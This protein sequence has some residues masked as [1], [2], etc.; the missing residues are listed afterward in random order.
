[1]SNWDEDV[2]AVLNKLAGCTFD[3][4]LT[5]PGT[6]TLSA[7]RKSYADLGM[8]IKRYE[9]MYVCPNCSKTFIP[10][11]PNEIDDML[12]DYNKERNKGK[13]VSSLICQK[14]AIMKALE[15]NFA[16][17]DMDRVLRTRKAEEQYGPDGEPF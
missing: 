12:Q 3:P 15:V 8:L 6:F 5:Q 2:K 11:A 4:A 9:A 7:L 16:D 1:M 17:V 10:A 13:H 14:Y